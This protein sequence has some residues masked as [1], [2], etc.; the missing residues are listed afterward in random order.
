MGTIARALFALLLSLAGGGTHAQDADVGLVQQVAG[1][2]SYRGASGG[3]KVQAFMKMRQG[4]RYDLA[5]GATLRVVYF[6]N[7][8]QE[9]WRGPASFRCQG[10]SSDALKGAAAQVATLPVAVPKKLQKIPDLIQMAQM[11]GVQVRGVKTAPKP[12]PEQK[13]ELAAARVTYAEL[14][15]QLPQD[16]ITPEL[17]LFT[18]LQDHLLYEEMQTVVDDMLRRQPGNAEAQQL[19]EWVRARLARG[20]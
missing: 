6:S 14:R 5:A 3:G 11:G 10:E 9:T 2:V 17:Y 7:G 13:E 8:R 15:R 16:D 20:K 19:A 12:G 1:E 18:V 4:D